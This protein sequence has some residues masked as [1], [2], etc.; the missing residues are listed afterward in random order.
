MSLACAQAER[1]AEAD[2]AAVRAA[3]AQEAPAPDAEVG[4][5][6]RAAAFAQQMQAK[7][8]GHAKRPADVG[9]DAAAPADEDEASGSDEEGGKRA[10]VRSRV[11]AAM[12]TAPHSPQ[13]CA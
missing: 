1:A 3:A 2:A 5:D 4:D 11:T 13:S 6:E 9:P 7:A 12:Q 10:K 8:R